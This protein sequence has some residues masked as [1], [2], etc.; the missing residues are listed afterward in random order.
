[1]IEAGTVNAALSLESVIVAPPEGAAEE[2]VTVQAVVL[3]VGTLAGEQPTEVTVSVP[4]KDNVAC[5]ELLLKVAVRVTVCVLVIVPAVAAKVAVVPPAATVTEAGTVNRGLLLD[6]KT[7]APPAGAGD[8]SVT[9]HVELTPLP[10]VVAVHPIEL[11]MPCALSESVTCWE[12][13]P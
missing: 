13:P 2:R 6:S 12:P 3:L 7:L 1:V 9:V 5:C 4:T 10:S 11:R 8:V